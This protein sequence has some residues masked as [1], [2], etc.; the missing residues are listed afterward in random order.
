MQMDV[1]RVLQHWSQLRHVVVSA[2]RTAIHPNLPASVKSHAAA[3]GDD[4]VVLLA[5]TFVLATL[6]P[7]L[8]LACRRKA[9]VASKP[10]DF[11]AESTSHLPHDVLACTACNNTIPTDAASLRGSSV[12]AAVQKHRSGKRHR[13]ACEEMHTADDEHTLFIWDR[14]IKWEKSVARDGDGEVDDGSRVISADEAARKRAAQGRGGTAGGPQILG[15]GIAM[16][17]GGQDIDPAELS[18]GGWEKVPV[19]AGKVK[20]KKGEDGTGTGTG[21]GG[22]EALNAASIAKDIMANM[23][24]ME[25]SRNILDGVVVHNRFL[26]GGAESQLLT[27]V[28]QAIRNGQTGRWRGSTFTTPRPVPGTSAPGQPPAQSPLTL[29]FGCYYNIVSHE[30]ET[31]RSV[32]PLPP[33][34]VDLG[35]RIAQRGEWLAGLR[36]GQKAPVPD[37]AT[38]IGTLLARLYAASPLHAHSFSLDSL[39]SCYRGSTCRPTPSPARAMHLIHAS[40]STCWP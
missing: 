5:A 26:T 35:K 39:Q 23:L 24:H 31:A 1:N 4:A 33:V 22:G 11:D 37:C 15:Q 27:W 32:E 34:L 12:N 3:L 2:W 7:C 28:E 8:A 36:S 17:A 25:G 20:S 21:T 30:V 16:A 40:P 18:K 9:T 14:A 13:R 19:A 38:V 10:R 6:L 29:N